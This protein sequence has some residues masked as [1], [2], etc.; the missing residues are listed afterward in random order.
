M[1]KIMF[2]FTFTLIIFTAQSVV[3]TSFQSSEPA[4]SWDKLL[5]DM[6]PSLVI[7]QEIPDPQALAT[8][9]PSREFAIEDENQLIPIQVNIKQ[10]CESHQGQ[11]FA[12]HPTQLTKEYLAAFTASYIIP[13]L[14]ANSIACSVPARNGRYCI[15]ASPVNVVIMSDIYKDTCN[16]FY[17]AYWV[18][19]Y[20]QSFENM[21]TLLSKGRTVYPVPN[22]IFKGEV[23]TG[24][25]Y[26]V[27]EREF[28]LITKASNN[29]IFRSN[30]ESSN[31]LKSGQ[32]TLKDH[33]FVSFK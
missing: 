5:E 10:E 2:K 18:T 1:S 23:Y 24:S 28:I 13:R 14:P 30:Q 7:S 21:G 12:A 31:S 6:V 15:K 26:P 4:K 29:E 17:R 3:A 20:L 11:L 16:Q 22:S 27:D 8:W 9:K 33:L 19:T 25:T 32:Y